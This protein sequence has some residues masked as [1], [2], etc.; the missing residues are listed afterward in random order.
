MST[1]NE[2]PKLEAGMVIVAEVCYEEH[3]YLYV[4]DG[5]WLNLSGKS[6]V[7]CVNMDKI[8]MICSE[9]TSFAFEEQGDDLE[10]RI[11]WKRNTETEDKIE[12]LQA[13]I[14]RALKELENIKKSL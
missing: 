9:Q 2:M 12:A 1:K 10:S 3:A 11:I 5:K 6:G 4:K 8:T 14:K 7:P 13:I